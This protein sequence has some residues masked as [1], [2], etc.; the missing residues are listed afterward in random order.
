MVVIYSQE[1]TAIKNNAKE[2]KEMIL[3]LY[4][5]KLGNEAYETI[6]SEIKGVSYRKNGGPLIR[7]I[8][9]ADA[10]EIRR[11][12]QEIGMLKV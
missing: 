12:E 11:H 1:F 3:S 7:V 9:S 5:D 8:S 2:A 10:C 6:K 4:G